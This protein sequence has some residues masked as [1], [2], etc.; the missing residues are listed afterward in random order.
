MLTTEDRLAI[1]ELLSQ[2]GHLVDTGAW[3]QLDALFTDDVVYDLRDYGGSELHGIAALV[4][5]S[6]ELGDKNPV[7]HHVTNVVITE[8]DGTVVRVRSK[9][10]GIHKDGTCGSVTYEDELRRG[11]H[12]WRIA[13]RRVRPR[14]QALHP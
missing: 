14:R 4:A 1:H 7:A 8:T 2:H 6:Q 10:I 9:G 12:G 5:A 13:R 11:E 3:D